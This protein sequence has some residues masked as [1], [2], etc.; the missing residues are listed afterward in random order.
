MFKYPCFRCLN[1]ISLACLNFAIWSH[2]ALG[3]ALCYMSPNSTRILK[4]H[5]IIVR[6]TTKYFLSMISLHEFSVAKATLQ[7]QM[8]VHLSPKPPYSFKSIISPY[9]YLHHH[10]SVISQSSVSHQKL[11]VIT[12][13][14]IQHPTFN[15]HLHLFIDRLLRL[16]GLFNGNPLW[17]QILASV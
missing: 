14:N 9:H 16:F 8:S 1:I 3:F 5:S 17:I 13:G 2:I 11:S 4:Q 6:F 7:Q 15:Y 10:Q 12:V